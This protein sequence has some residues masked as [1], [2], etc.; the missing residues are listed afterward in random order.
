MYDPSLRPTFVEVLSVCC[1]DCKNSQK[2]PYN[3][4]TVYNIKAMLRKHTNVFFNVKQI[5]YLF[6]IFFLI[7]TNSQTKSY[8]GWSQV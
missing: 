8:E 3:Q 4:T 6:I 1:I 2:C 5:L 7:V